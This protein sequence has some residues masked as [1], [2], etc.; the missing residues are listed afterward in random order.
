MPPS[1]GTPEHSIRAEPPDVLARHAEAVE[2]RGPSFGEEGPVGV[3]HTI[4]KDT[5]FAT[6]PDLTR[7]W[8]SNTHYSLYF[9]LSFFLS[10]ETFCFSCFSFLGDGTRDTGRWGPDA[11]FPFYALSRAEAVEAVGAGGSGRRYRSATTFAHPVE[12]N[13]PLFLP[14]QFKCWESGSR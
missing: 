14:L 3:P 4:L 12:R 11:H 6:K 5:S 1:H 2:A 13:V 7:K 9:Y 8:G 10:R